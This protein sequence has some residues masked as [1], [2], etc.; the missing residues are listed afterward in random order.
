MCPVC[1]YAVAVLMGYGLPRSNRRYAVA[2]IV[3]ATAFGDNPRAVN[4]DGAYLVA[5][6]HYL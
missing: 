4:F 2:G 1:G 6:G 5:K 3:L